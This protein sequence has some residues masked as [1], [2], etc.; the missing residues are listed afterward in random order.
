MCV[1][2]LGCSWLEGEETVCVCVDVGVM[3]VVVVMEKRGGRSFPI[4]IPSPPPS[5]TDGK[6]RKA[7]FATPLPAL[8]NFKARESLTVPCNINP[9]KIMAV[10]A[11]THTT[12]TGTVCSFRC[13]FSLVC[14]YVMSLDVRGAR[15]M[16]RPTRKG[17]VTCE[18]AQARVRTLRKRV[19]AAPACVCV[20]VCVFLRGRVVPPLVWSQR[21]ETAKEY[22]RP[23]RIP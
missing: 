9:P 22:Q 12:N 20:C 14:V 4:L 2:V 11:N 23:L 17:L 13:R 19:V 5:P 3:V 1:C 16:A 15:R 10:R 8:A 6:R 7:A 18:P 21:R